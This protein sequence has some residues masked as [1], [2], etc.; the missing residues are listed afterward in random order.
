MQILGGTEVSTSKNLEF[1][2]SLSYYAIHLHKYSTLLFN[3]PLMGTFVYS[4]Y[5]NNIK[6]DT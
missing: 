3:V 4:P 1:F 5:E 6:K 2:H